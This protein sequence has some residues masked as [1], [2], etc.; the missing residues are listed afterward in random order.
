M[1]VLIHGDA[2]FAGQGVVME[3]LQLSQARG[4]CT[5]GT[6]PRRDQQPGRLHDQRSARRALD[7]ATARDVA[8]MVEAPVFH[9]NGDDPEA[10]VFARGSR[11][12][13]RPEFHKDVVIDLV[14]YRR[15]GHNEADE[16]AATQPVM[17]QAIRE[18]PEHARAVRRASSC[19]DGVIDA[20][21]RA[22]RLVEEYRNEL[23]E[24]RNR[25]KRAL[26]M[27]GNE[28]TVDWSRYT[29]A[30]TGATR[31]HGRR[32]RR[33]RASSRPR[34]TRVPAGFKLHPRVQRI[35]DERRRDGRRRAR[36]GLGLRRDARLRDAARRR[37]S[38][39]RLVGQDSRPRHV[40]PPP[41]RRCTTRAPAT[42]TS[43]SQHVASEPARAHASPTRCCPR[44]RC[45]ASSTAT[46]TTPTRHA[47]DLGRPVRR[48][49]ERRAG[50]DRPVHQLRRSQVG[51]HL[52]AHAVPAARL[53]RPGSGA[54]VRA[55]RALPA[56]L[57][58][59]QHAGLRAVDAGADVP[60]A[61]PADAAAR[62]ASRSIVMTPKSL[63]RHK[64]SVS[65]LDDLAQRPL[66]A[67]IDE[68]DDR[69]ADERS[70]ASCSAPARCITTCSRAPRRATST[71]SRS[72][73]S[74]SSIRSRAR[75]TLRVIAR[76]PQRAR[77]RL[78]PGR[79]AEPGRVV[80]DPASPAG[81]ARAEQELLYAGRARAAAPA[82]GIHAAA[83]APA[84]G[85]GRRSAARRPRERAESATAASRA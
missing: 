34:S 59:A 44:K 52:R 10:A 83:R 81:T 20:R 67:V 82:A 3:T 1:P 30:S 49:R 45:S 28:Y 14:C 18:Q 85:A 36:A 24:G 23:D 39:M 70:R 46:R 77:G 32:P 61:A 50:R 11:C 35:I 71:M 7:D 68:I 21:R 12:D 31:S 38:T 62:S 53:R 19:E 5:G 63:L 54:L 64:L 80:P 2:A 16:P 27:I 73:A 78:V 33:A 48:L 58:R 17:Y 29:Q 76:Y 57:R 9:V 13:Y 40:L 8:K 37:T 79:A 66:P 69:C 74:S 4:F 75:S 6:D 25:I 51:P 22:R 65:T 47:R 26:G 84:A 72:C 15:H 42:R 56:A 41:R 43:R 55:P 60:H